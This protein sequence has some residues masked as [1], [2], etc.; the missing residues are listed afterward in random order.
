T[1]FVGRTVPRGIEVGEPLNHFLERQILQFEQRPDPGRPPA[2]IDVGAVGRIFEDQARNTPRYLRDELRRDERAEREAEQRD[3]LKA[4]LVEDAEDIA[5][6][7]GVAVA[8]LR[9]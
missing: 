1:Q 9:L 3:L 5:G 2:R 8:F 6:I 4:E 7:V